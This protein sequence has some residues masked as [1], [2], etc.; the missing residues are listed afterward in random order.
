MIRTAIIEKVMTSNYYYTCFF[1][2]GQTTIEIPKGRF[3]LNK[4]PR[5]KKGDKLTIVQENG[6]TSLFIN[7]KELKSTKNL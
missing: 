6:Q 4:L 3:S 1:D 2:G 7:N 5:P